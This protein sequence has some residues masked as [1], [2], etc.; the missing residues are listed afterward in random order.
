VRFG[1]I[2][3]QEPYKN[4]HVSE[5]SATAA[6]VPQPQQ[7]PQQPPVLQQQQPIQQPQPV[8]PPQQPIV[9]PPQLPANQPNLPTLLPLPVVVAPPPVVVAPLSVGV[10]PPLPCTCT[11]EVCKCLQ[12]PQLEAV[13]EEDEPDIPKQQRPQKVDL[14]VLKVSLQGSSPE[15]QMQ[16]E[17]PH[18]I[19]RPA[20][21]QLRDA[22]Q[23]LALSPD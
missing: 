23:C 15:L 16:Q 3:Y 14:T 7:Q 22:F 10:A 9:L 2:W 13:Q 6:N 11:P 5:H 19:P 4:Y 21:D 8:L 12:P 20:A 17:R 18:N 1:D